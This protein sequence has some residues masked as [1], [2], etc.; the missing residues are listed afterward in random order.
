M[1]VQRDLSPL[2]AEPLDAA[3]A[4]FTSA[5]GELDFEVREVVQAQFLMH[6]VVTEF[7][8]RVPAATSGSA[9]IKVNHHGAIRRQGLACKV[10][11]GDA[12]ELDGLLA[13]L[14]GDA[15]LLAALMPLDFKRLWIE[16]EGRHWVVRLEHMGASEVVSRMPSFRRYIRL[17][18]VQRQ[19]LLQAFRALQ[20][21]LGSH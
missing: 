21:I 12:Q 5:D 1:Q 4:R 3:T 7:V 13:R 19:H 16:W 14:Q 20:G 9:R 11:A 6:L 15:G 17:A 10:R 2:R 8:L 18:P